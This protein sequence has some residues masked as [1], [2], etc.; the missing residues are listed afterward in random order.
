MGLTRSDTER[1]LAAI[2]DQ[3]ASIEREVL[4]DVD[5]AP[6]DLA[7]LPAD[8]SIPDFLRRTA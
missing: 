5:A 6:S 1:F 4:Q 7:A 3:I 8:L 2:R